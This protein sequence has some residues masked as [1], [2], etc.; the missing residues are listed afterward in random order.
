MGE[1]KVNRRHNT[2]WSLFGFRSNYSNVLG[3]GFTLIELLIVI[4]VIGILA[5]TLVTLI[6]PG[7]QLRKAR[8]TQ[9][10]SDLSRIQSAIEV[11]KADLN[12][13]PC[14]TAGPG[15][16]AVLPACT[17]PLTGGAP[18]L[19]YMNQVPCDPLAPP[20]PYKYRTNATNSNYCVRTCLENIQDRDRDEIKFGQNNPLIGTTCF[21]IGAD[22]CPANRRSYTVLNP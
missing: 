4:A 15:C 5:G 22:N 14:S 21:F 7:A 10:K 2:L 20:N 1:E 3:Y 19:T 12:V 8:D 13:Y 11:F 9:R 16:A 18:P 17:L 6:N